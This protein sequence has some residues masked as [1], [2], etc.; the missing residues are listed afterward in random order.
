MRNLGAMMWMCAVLAVIGCS[1]DEE[2]PDPGDGTTME[3]TVEHASL[4]SISGE[5]AD[6]Y[7]QL[8]TR[9]TIVNRGAEPI[10]QVMLDGFSFPGHLSNAGLSVEA[11][12]ADA[13][14]EPG[15]EASLTF[16][17]VEDGQL[18]CHAGQG[19]VE[20]DAELE[21]VIDGVSA[22]VATPGRVAC[23]EN[24]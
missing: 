21:F 8:S 3:L 13:A 10:F 22:V 2:T 14:I 7:L 11:D 1:S 4:D 17:Y 23:G 6:G 15:S 5:G 20:V 24:F 12:A 9:L 18:A 16:S 19:S